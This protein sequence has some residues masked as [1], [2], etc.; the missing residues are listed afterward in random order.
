MSEEKTIKVKETR[1]TRSKH[2]GGG[3]AGKETRVVEV[4]ATYELSSFAEQ[5]PD[6]TPITDWEESK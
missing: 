3:I 2:G 5:V 4:P 1:L 6:E